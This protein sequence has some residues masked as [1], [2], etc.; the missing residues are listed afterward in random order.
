M[1]RDLFGDINIDGKIIFKQILNTSER[2][3]S[4]GSGQITV[5]GFCEHGNELPGFIK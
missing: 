4:S 2:L 1:E 3:D 5:T